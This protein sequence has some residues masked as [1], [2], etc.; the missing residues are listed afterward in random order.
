MTK[1]SIESGSLIEN[2]INRF[3]AANSDFSGFDQKKITIY[4][5]KRQVV[6]EYSSLA[7]SRASYLENT[8]RN[9]KLD[10]T[11]RKKLEEEISQKSEIDLNKLTNLESENDKFINKVFGENKI[12]KLS[13]F[14]FLDSLSKE[15]IENRL[16]KLSESDK[17]SVK[18]SLLN[19]KDF[20]V[21]NTDIKELFSTNFL[22]KNE[23]KE[24][25]SQFIPYLT[26]KK[27]K[28]L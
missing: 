27:A 14:T 2:K 3:Q 11:Q 23:K 10:E 8:F 22:N 20:R 9:Y 13:N 6:K 19:L 15:D 4:D 5:L 16:E 25:L 26:L 17:H 18:I 1:D 7:N 21:K 12:D 24:I 28:E